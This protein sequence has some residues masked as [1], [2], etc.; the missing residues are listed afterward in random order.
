MR[1]KLGKFFEKCLLLLLESEPEI[2]HPFKTQRKAD[3]DDDD[4]D[5]DDNDDDDDVDDDDKDVYRLSRKKILF[6]LDLKLGF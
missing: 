3:D 1:R 4:D 2:F 6:D 5:D